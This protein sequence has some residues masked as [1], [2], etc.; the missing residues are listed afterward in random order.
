MN[1]YLFVYGTL[2]QAIKHPLHQL[3]MTYADYI[4][5]AYLQGQLYEVTTYPAAIIS[6][7][8][9]DKVVGELYKLNNAP[10]LLAVLDDYEECSPRFAQPHEYLRIQHKV[11]LENGMTQLA[12]M[13]CY[14]GVVS[15]L[16]RIITGD[17]VAP[18]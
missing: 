15:P 18:W 12:W 5:N 8:N 3:I 6:N 1:D 13:Y 9:K 4:A 16:K 17:Y 7:N 11:S 2:R 14:Q 10:L